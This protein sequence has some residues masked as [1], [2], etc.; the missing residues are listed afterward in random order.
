MK[1]RLPRGMGGAPQDMNTMIKQAQKMQEIMSTTTAE[2]E[3]KE[4][5]TTV[6]GGAVKA[7][8]SGKKELISLTISPDVVD[9]DDIEM[10]QDL[11]ISGI[12]ECIRNIEAESEEAM[13]KIS[14]GIQMPF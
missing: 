4:Y 11:L 5:E 13:T 10:L 12:N 14:G 9:K 3:A 6:G 8:L 7:V 2:L 1:A